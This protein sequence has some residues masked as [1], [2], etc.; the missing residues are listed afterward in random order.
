MEVPQLPVSHSKRGQKYNLF[1][2]VGRTHLVGSRQAEAVHNRGKAEYRER[3]TASGA[4]PVKVRKPSGRVG[5]LGLA[6]SV[7][8][9]VAASLVLL[10]AHP[11]AALAAAPSSPSGTI[12]TVAGNGIAGYGGDGGPATAAE[13]NEP[14]GVAIDTSGNL[15]IS[16]TNNN[17]VRL[18][19]EA[20]PRACHLRPGGRVDIPRLSAWQPKPA[21]ASP[22]ILSVVAAARLDPQSWPDDPG[23]RL[24]GQLGDETHENA[25]LLSLNIIT[26]MVPMTPP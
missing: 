5:G 7:A 10:G 8:T 1:R 6:C 15:L 14:Q 12:S 9:F 21:R 16:D 26:H 25:H 11:S 13:L 24:C 2:V 19:I 3:C 20:V 4:L 22:G 17:R 18:V 23:L